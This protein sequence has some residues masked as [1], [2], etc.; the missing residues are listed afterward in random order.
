MSVAKV[1]LL[2]ATLAACSDSS[3][4]DGEASISGNYTLRTING[5]N[6]PFAL[7]VVGTTYRLEV[8]AAN[9]L[10]NSN[11]TYNESGTLREIANG[12]TTTQ[13]ET[14]NGTWTR[15]NNAITFR[16]T[17]DGALV[18]AALS[19]NTITIVDGEFTYVYR[20]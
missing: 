4:P 11:G 9:I 6:L 20:K 19:E 13:T 16:Q 15:A 10:I 3:G 12:T 14:S 7:V 17:S 1:L 18:N 5:N 8:T 2:T